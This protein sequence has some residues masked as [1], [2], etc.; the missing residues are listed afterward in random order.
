MWDK[1]P[2]AD[3]NLILDPLVVID[4]DY[5]VVFA[6]DTAK[7]VFGE[8]KESQ[9]CYSYKTFARKPFALAKG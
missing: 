4:K 9:K 7:E 6:N 3:L 2:K 8:I 5:N 1:V